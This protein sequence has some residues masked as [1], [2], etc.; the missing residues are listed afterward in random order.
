[1]AFGVTFKRYE[2]KYLLSPEQYEAVKEQ[3]DKY[4]NP[5]K[6]GETTICN[7]YYDTSDYLLIQR[8]ID[9][10]VFKEKVRLRTYGVPSDTTTSFLEVKRKFNKIVYKRRIHLPYLEAIDFVA[11]LG[12]S[13]LE[14]GVN[15]NSQI[16][17]EI[18]YLLKLYKDLAPKFYISY[19]RCAFFYK[20]NDA[21]RI[22][23]DKNLTW[24][25]YDLDLRLGSYGEQLLPDGYTIMEIKVPN[26]VP[27]WLAKLLSEQ[28]IYATSFSKVGTA[29]RTMLARRLG[30]PA[31][32]TG[33]PRLI[34]QDA[35]KVKAS[36][37]KE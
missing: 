34:Q 15:D 17:S 25:D 24:R 14:R 27:L 32:T 36:S 26:T 9:K 11:S 4:F 3:V 18:T 37:S 13:N 2:K 6:Y 23:F 5:D 8:S 29:Y 35:N 22:T 7:L 1:M 19:D 20:E 16:M 28:K 12:N 10:P 33:N 30:R 31:I 21:I